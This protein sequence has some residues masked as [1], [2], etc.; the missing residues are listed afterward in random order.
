MARYKYKAVNNT[1]RAA[2]G[3]LEA[4]SEA[5]LYEQLQR[6]GMELVSCSPIVEGAGGFSVG[7]P[8]G[9]PKVR[10]LIQL[11]VHLEQMQSA[12]VPLLNALNDVRASSES[13]KLRDVMTTVYQDVSDGA[14]LSEAMGAHPSVFK[15][16]YLSLIKAGEHTGDMGFAYRQLIKYLKWLDG[17]QTLVR[18]A[19]R[20]PMILLVVVV[21]VIVVMMGFVVPAV[22]EFLEED[23]DVELP[24]ATTSLIWTKDMF[25]G[26]W[27]AILGAPVLAFFGIMG[28]YKTMP[29]FAYQVDK[30]ILNMPLAGMLVRKISIARYTQTFGAMFA[31]GINVLKALHAAGHTIN[32]RVL[33]EAVGIVE[34]K[35][36]EGAPMSEAFNESGEFPS[37][38]VHMVKVGEETGNLKAVMDQVSDFYT[39][40]VNEAVESL[41]TMIE[42][43]LTGI[44]G[45]M[46]LWIAVGVFQPIY[47]NLGKLT[48]AI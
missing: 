5:D 39:A 6:G 28:L 38:V 31:S 29:P 9:G 8:T 33:K 48:E 26:Y 30:I 10:D 17:M 16:L 7:L 40:D 22:T 41:I 13:P 14:S 27:W 19:T 37:L 15:D 12:G 25:L 44:L 47:G 42:P 21:A 32:N 23:M 11:F 3:V 2:R 35:V 20:Y 4:A 43:L 45:F 46:I 36:R 1:G 34:N 24:F 18:K